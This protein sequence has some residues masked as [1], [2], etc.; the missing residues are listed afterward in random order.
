[1][2]EGPKYDPLKNARQFVKQCKSTGQKGY[3]LSG[4]RMESGGR[5]NSLS[6]VIAGGCERRSSTFYCNPFPHWPGG[7]ISAKNSAPFQTQHV[8]QNCVHKFRPLRCGDRQAT[9]V[10]FSIRC[11]IDPTK[12]P[13]FGN[14]SA[15]RQR[16]DF[17]NFCPRPL[18]CVR[19]YAGFWTTPCFYFI[20]FQN[21]HTPA[22]GCDRPG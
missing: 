19:T 14:F 8:Q 10:E 4:G 13:E 20:D 22:A 18:V 3:N 6:D 9:G 21:L 1:M 11:A 15:E 2:E 17:V 7:K 16:A 5:R 12:F